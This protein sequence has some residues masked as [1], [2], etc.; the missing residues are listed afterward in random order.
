MA[1]LHVRPPVLSLELTRT[2]K[3][4]GLL[5]DV[6]IPLSAVRDAK[7]VDDAVGTPRGWRVGLGLPGLRR[8]GIWRHTGQ[9]TLV[10]VRRGQPAVRV[11]L[12]GERWDELL[13]GDDDA[14][15]V[16]A[17]IVAAR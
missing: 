15:A 5:R 16:A 1:L 7:V 9:K 6:E 8:I 10:S 14:E 13:I 12:E 11:R 3:V 4:L 2:E 17:A